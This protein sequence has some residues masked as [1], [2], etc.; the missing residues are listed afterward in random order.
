MLILGCVELGGNG[1]KFNRFHVPLDG[2]RGDIEP[3]GHLPRGGTFPVEQVYYYREQTVG[4]HGYA[5]I[6]SIRN[7]D[8]H[9]DFPTEL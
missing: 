1:G 6:A 3:T 7:F 5:M 9:T 8:P 2:T 4:F